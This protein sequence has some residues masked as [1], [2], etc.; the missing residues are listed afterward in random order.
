MSLQDILA[1]CKEVFSL[2]P[3]SGLILE[4]LSSTLFQ[5][6]HS[7]VSGSGD[8]CPGF[9]EEIAASV[10]STESNAVVA[11]K[12]ST[13]SAA[14]P[15]TDDSEPTSYECSQD[16]SPE[17]DDGAMELSRP[18]SPPAIS[19]LSPKAMETAGCI[20][21]FQQQ[22]REKAKVRKIM[23]YSA[24]CLY[25]WKNGVIT[26]AQLTFKSAISDSP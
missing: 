1:G 17:P 2:S 23:V 6:S 20:I 15:L 9:S 10:S 22:Q 8:S 5:E 3:R 19:L 4:R 21:K 24:E 16:E 25:N 11:S 7:Q 12:H 26:I 14:R 18:L 13:P